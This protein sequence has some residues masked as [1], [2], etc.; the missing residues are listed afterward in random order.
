AFADDTASTDAEVETEHFRVVSSSAAFPASR[1]A[2]LLELA[3]PQW[4][5]LFERDDDRRDRLQVRV[6][7]D[8]GSF[9]RA[10]G[11][12]VDDAIGIFDPSSGVAHIHAPTASRVCIETLLHEVVHQ[13]HELGAAQRL[14]PLAPWYCE[15][16]ATLF[17]ESFRWVGHDL[18]VRWDETA[19]AGARIRTDDAVSFAWWFG[20]GLQ[21][22]RSSD[23]TKALHGIVSSSLRRFDAGT[24]HD[25]RR[26]YGLGAVLVDFLRSESP[27]PKGWHTLIT[28]LD[29]GDQ[30]DL[31]RVARACGFRSERELV[32]ALLK[33]IPRRCPPCF[34]TEGTFDFD[35]Q[36]RIVHRAGG[37][38]GLIVASPMVRDLSV[39]AVDASSPESRLG[40]LV[41]WIDNSE[42]TAVYLVRTETTTTAV[43]AKL[44][45]GSWTVLD[46]RPCP[47]ST[48]DRLE[49]RSGPGDALTVRVN[50]SAVF[51][52]KRGSGGLGVYIFGAA[53]GPLEITTVRR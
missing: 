41:D 14:R 11:F 40:V 51:A 47:L 9:Q 19:G 31:A 22:C 25:T 5:A 15:G 52:P 27:K 36:G 4:R 30:P 18:K 49:V 26:R 12:G 42:F 24:L 8:A 2:S 53:V 43:L 46:S 34:V 48:R 1:A 23:P 16:L 39:R 17:S 10:T 28:R 7:G 13:Y 37:G 32:R 21:W 44:A 45:G 35:E 3:H 50:G 38:H 33:W 6:H 29:A 20:T